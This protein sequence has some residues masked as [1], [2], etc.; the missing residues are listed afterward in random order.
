M[1][2]E[3][4]KRCDNMYTG[5]G[6]IN[7]GFIEPL[8]RSHSLKKM[9]ENL[10]NI[11]E[12]VL[13]NLVRHHNEYASLPICFEI[14]A[15]IKIKAAIVIKK[16]IKIFLKK[17]LKSKKKIKNIDINKDKYNVAEDSKKIIQAKYHELNYAKIF[18]RITI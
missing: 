6:K 1:A 9:T 14:I 17:N 11:D 18:M 3:Y 7:N 5:P 16:Q 4:F 10:A 2:Y 8:P 13:E 15:F 12:T